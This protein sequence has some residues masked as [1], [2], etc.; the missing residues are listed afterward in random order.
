MSIMPAPPGAS[1][2]AQIVG[3]GSEG[4]GKADAR[5]TAELRLRLAGHRLDPAATH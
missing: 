2:G 4:E 3:S 1:A 5:H